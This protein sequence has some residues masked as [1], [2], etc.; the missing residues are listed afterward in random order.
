MSVY[1]P[2]VGHMSN[3]K[4]I[5]DQLEALD[6]AGHLAL[7]SSPKAVLQALT[8]AHERGRKAGIDEARAKLTEEIR[9]DLQAEAQRERKD[10]QAIKKQLEALKDNK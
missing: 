8:E 9:R 4:T 7:A 5:E 2:L 10:F 3:M 1:T 6:N